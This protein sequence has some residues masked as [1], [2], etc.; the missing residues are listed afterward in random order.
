M[1]VALYVAENW[2]SPEIAHPTDRVVELDDNGGYYTH[3]NRYFEGA[4]LPSHRGALVDL[5][6]ESEIDGYQLDR[7]E[8]EMNAALADATR[9]PDQWRVL[10][11]WN[12]EVS[13]AN[14]IWQV[15]DREKL[16]E[17]VKQILWLISF[18]R[19]R[20]LKLIALGDQN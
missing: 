16:V 9:R 5:Y 2:R 15:V 4:R 1:A 13:R 20:R 7:L 11:S 10:I 6:L 14:E 3:L 19:Q 18:A 17:I 12:G 8:D